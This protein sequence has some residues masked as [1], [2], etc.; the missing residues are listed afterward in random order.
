MDITHLTSRALPAFHRRDR[1]FLPEIWKTIASFL[2]KGQ[3]NQLLLVSSHFYRSLIAIQYL[4]LILRLPPSDLTTSEL[5][6][7]T[8]RMLASDQSLALCITEITFATS[9]ESRYSSPMFPDRPH[10]VIS[11]PP[12]F[13]KALKNLTRLRSITISCCLFLHLCEAEAEAPIYEI[14]GS[15]KLTSFCVEPLCHALSECVQVLRLGK[16]LLEPPGVANTK[17]ILL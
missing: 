8:L 14:L 7:A 17:S 9:G 4:H 13:F 1:L 10:F 11:L 15:L 2:S 16:Y 3:L 5:L 6:E 12:S